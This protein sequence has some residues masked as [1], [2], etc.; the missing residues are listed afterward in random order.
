MHFLYLKTT[1]SAE[2]VA[3]LRGYSLIQR[4]SKADMSERSL[5]GPCGEGGSNFWLQE[6]LSYNLHR[7]TTNDFL[8]DTLISWIRVEEGRVGAKRARRTNG[9]VRM[10]HLSSFIYIYR[11]LNPLPAGR[12]QSWRS[13]R[14]IAWSSNRRED[15]ALCG[16]LRSTRLN[17]SEPR[18]VHSQTKRLTQQNSKVA[19]LSPLPCAAHSLELLIVE[20]KNALQPP[21]LTGWIPRNAHGSSSLNILSI[22]FAEAKAF[23]VLSLLGIASKSR[24]RSADFW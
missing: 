14:L 20:T 10:L 16:G 8:P 9:P 21:W 24:L 11:L 23:E 1:F 4:V 12:S 7:H 22:P 3:A 2:Q 5:F 6:D 17:N 18:W 13:W 15:P 19:Q